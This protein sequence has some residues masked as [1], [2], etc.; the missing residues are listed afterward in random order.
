MT[1]RSDRDALLHRADSL[2]AQLAEANERLKLAREK[3]AAQEEKDEEDE[4]RLAELAAQVDVLR[5]RLGLPPGRVITKPKQESSTAKFVALGSLVVLALMLAGG[6]AVFAITSPGPGEPQPPPSPVMP[7]VL[8][9]AFALFGLPLVGLA[10]STFAKDRRIARWPRAPGTV[11]SSRIAS[12]TGTTRDKQGYSQ[13]YTSYTPE[14]TYRYV[15]DGTEYEGSAVARGELSTT[16]RSAVEACVDRYA[17]GNAIEVL[18]DPTDPT[19]AYLEVRRSIGALILL[20]F[21]GLLMGIGV[22]IIALVA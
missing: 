14:V 6:V 8:G 2:E 21:G 17:P 10:L 7:W 16:T 13:E 5:G 3:L 9:G 19:T 20:G 1:F 15:I 11:V 18:Y 12:S 22:L 4:R